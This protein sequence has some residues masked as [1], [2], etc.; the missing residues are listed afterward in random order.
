MSIS[1]IY[2]SCFSRL[3]AW[4]KMWAHISQPCADDTQHF[5]ATRLDASWLVWAKNQ[6]PSKSVGSRAFNTR[7]RLPKNKMLSLPG[8]N[9][10]KVTCI[11]HIF[12]SIPSNEL[13]RLF[14]I[15]AL[16]LQQIPFPLIF[17]GTF[18]VWFQAFSKLPLKCPPEAYIEM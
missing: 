17:S 7:K 12:C 14:T 15:P 5:R 11:V 10:I 9:T 6:G 18:L 13:G 2:P 4:H 16:L 8:W 3:S 1:L